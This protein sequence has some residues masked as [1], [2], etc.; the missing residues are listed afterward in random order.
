MRIKPFVLVIVLFSIFMGCTQDENDNQNFKGYVFTM[1]NASNGNEL[2]QYKINS[3]GTLNLIAS[4]P[5]TGLG[6]GS[7]LASQGSVILSVNKKT[8]FVV[9]AGDH[10]ISTFSILPNGSI[11]LVGKYFLQGIRPI[12]ITQRENLVYV[13]CSQGATGTASIEGFM[14]TTTGALTPI[15][16]SFLNLTSDVNP[17]QISFVHNG[18]L[19]VSE[20]VSNKLTTYTLNSILHTPTFSQS[21]TT[22]STQPYGFAVNSIGQIFVTEASASS[23]V[24]S[25]SITQTGIINSISSLSN[26]QSGACWA[27]INSTSTICY[28]SNAGANTIS[29][30]TISPSGSLTS[31][32]TAIELGTGNSPLDIGVSS[33]DEFLFVLAGTSDK[34]LPFKINDNNLSPIA[35]TPIYVPGSAYGLAVY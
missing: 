23:A 24:S 13:L 17:A 15:T 19:V 7:N 11:T 21:I 31:T 1:S 4:V 25:Y 14:M 20:R 8:V 5:T 26:A 16:N 32:Q 10:S 30:F 27:A 28:S 9:N 34:I 22:L 18:V 12:S 6:S 3:N 35:T 29:T 33:N 2:L